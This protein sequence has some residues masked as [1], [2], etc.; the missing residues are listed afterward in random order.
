MKH[1]ELFENFLNEKAQELHQSMKELALKRLKEAIKN[2]PKTIPV[3]FNH[4]YAHLLYEDPSG[5]NHLWQGA[6]VKSGE[7]YL[8][9]LN[10]DKPTKKPAVKITHWLMDENGK[11]LKWVT[12][13][14]VDIKMVVDNFEGKKAKANESEQMNEEQDLDAVIKTALINHYKTYDGTD[15]YGQMPISSLVVER[16]IKDKE[17]AA[18]VNNFIKTGKSKLVVLQSYGGRFG[19]YEAISV[20]D[21]NLQKELSAALNTNKDRNDKMNQW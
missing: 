5:K 6:I 20:K 19:N 4:S 17:L 13:S 21:K 7:K 18:K 9:W 15:K 8:I 2:N 16:I 14:N 12:G 3:Y 11:I 10:M 1:L